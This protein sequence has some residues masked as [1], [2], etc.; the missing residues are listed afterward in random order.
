VLSSASLIFSLWDLIVFSNYAVSPRFRVSSVRWI[1]CAA[2]MFCFP[3]QGF[4]QT[5]QTALSKLVSL[6]S[7]VNDIEGQFVQFMVDSRGT[8]VQ[9]V[10]GDFKAKR[11]DYFFWRTSQPLEQVIY[12]WGEE[13][14]VYDPDLEQASIQQVG[15][16]LKATP[17]VLFSGDA[18]DIA[19]LF[20]VEYIAIDEQIDQFMLYPKQKDSLFELLRVRFTAGKISDMRISDAL[21]QDTTVSFIQTQINNGLSTQVFRPDLPS[22]VDIIRSADL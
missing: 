17:A 8:R 11:P 5:D 13:V 18:D 9:E 16:Q 2:L 20:V 6:L 7:P 14:T 22:S 15:E 19:A 4:S 1:L 21:G 3:N 10:R 12:V